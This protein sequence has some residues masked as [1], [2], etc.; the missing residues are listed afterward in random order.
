MN[1]MRMQPGEYRLVDVTGPYRALTFPFL[2]LILVTG[3]L[4]IVIGWMDANAVDVAYRNA[5][6]VLWAL[7][8]AWRFVLPL[9]RER[10]RRF[11]VTNTRVIAR[12]GS[13]VDSIPLV[14]IAGVRRRR[15]GITLTIRGYDRVLYFP[16]LPSTKRIERTISEELEQLQLAA[17]R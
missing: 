1:L 5:V 15:G 13:K 16:S 14:D 17:W 7:L 4:W 10:R 12:T 6:V 2:E 3:V 8:G 9:M 11:I